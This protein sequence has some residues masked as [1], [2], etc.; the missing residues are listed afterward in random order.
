MLLL[1]LLLIFVTGHGIIDG[2]YNFLFLLLYF[3][4]SLPQ[5]MSQLIVVPYLVECHKS[6][7]LK[8]PCHYNPAF[9]RL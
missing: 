2:I 9:I 4:L 5:Q 1:T 7:F 8:S 3:I 6:S